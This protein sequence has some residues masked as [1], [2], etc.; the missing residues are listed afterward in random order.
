M[1]NRSL[2]RRLPWAYQVLL[3]GAIYNCKINKDEEDSKIVV[4]DIE[5]WET[6]EFIRIRKKK[7]TKRLSHYIETEIWERG[8]LL[9]V[10]KYEPY[11]R[12]KAA[13]T[14]S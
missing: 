10:V 8:E 3:P 6:P 12:N 5:E 13:L 2:P 4:E 11:I 7:R 14:L 1:K 9:T